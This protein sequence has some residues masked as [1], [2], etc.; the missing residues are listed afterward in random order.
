VT[1]QHWPI[2]RELTQFES[3]VK[4]RWSLATSPLL[5]QCLETLSLQEPTRRNGLRGGKK[6]EGTGNH[7]GGFKIHFGGVEGSS[8]SGWALQ[9]SN[10]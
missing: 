9:D 10:L 3:V 4:K 6:V 8:V 1:T 7:R 5:M 2:R